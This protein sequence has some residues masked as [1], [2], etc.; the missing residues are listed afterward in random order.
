MYVLLDIEW[1][2]HA[3]E[4]SDP[5]RWLTQLSAAR[6]DEKWTILE[7]FDRIVRPIDPANCNWNF[8]AYNGYTPEQ[9]LDAESEEKCIRAFDEWLKEDDVFLCWQEE[10]KRT[11]HELYRRHLGHKCRTH[12]I[13]IKYGIE[14]WLRESGRTTN[15]IYNAAKFCGCKVSKPKH[16]SRLDVNLMQNI[17]SH[18]DLPVNQF[19]E[20]YP[21]P[22]SKMDR[23]R[24]DRR[25]RNAKRME[26]IETEFLYTPASS[27]FHR[28]GC[29]L[30]LCAKEIRGCKYYK[31][32][33]LN[34]R[35]CKVCKPVPLQEELK[36]LPHKDRPAQKFKLRK[37]F[38]SCAPDIPTENPEIFVVT[39][40][41]GAQ[42]EIA[43]QDLVGCCYSPVHPGKIDLKLMKR[44]RCE[45]KHCR[46]FEAYKGTRG[47]KEWRAYK[48]RL[49]KK[50]K[51]ARSLAEKEMQKSQS[52]QDSISSEEV[53]ATRQEP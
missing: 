37:G 3:K 13:R 28:R 15:G 52:E 40:L 30:L 14:N 48:H 8:M 46:Y 32:A 21:K 49:D 7:R 11:M 6:V 10:T 27:V 47:W 20:A 1:V 24:L 45:F 51:K 38:I 36:K 53:E 19:E 18:L 29:K 23:K 12:S 4:V 39:M 34:R 17:L 33:A 42:K 16:C 31:T 43:Q 2:D 41:G 35:P 50:N 26:T 22:Q 44:H 5:G 9:F 25:K